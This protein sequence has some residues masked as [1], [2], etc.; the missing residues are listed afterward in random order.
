MSGL[1]T[2]DVVEGLGALAVVGSLVFVAMEL[3]QANQIG[4]L[5]AMQSMATEWASIGLDIATDEGLS[6]LVGR[7][8][9]GDVAE[10]FDDTENAQLAN[11]F[12]GLDHNWNLRFKQLRLG[13]L[14]PDDYSFPAR[15][16]FYSSAYHKEMWPS[17]RSEFPEE[18]AVFWE[19]R[20][21]LAD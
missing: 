10:D 16:S 14:K 8:N 7:V 4:R 2:R 21:Q 18:F 1:R 17:I 3:R 12:Y 11:L 5:E 9:A 6:A 15:F 20:F 19:Q 13:V